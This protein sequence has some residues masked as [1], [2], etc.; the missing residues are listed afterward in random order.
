MNFAAGVGRVAFP[1]LGETGK[2]ATAK[3]MNN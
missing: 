1:P 2:G 3:K